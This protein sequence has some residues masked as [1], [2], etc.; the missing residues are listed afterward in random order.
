MPAKPSPVVK[1]TPAKEKSKKQNDDSDLAN[2]LSLDN[3]VK[4]DPN[5]KPQ[6]GGKPGGTGSNPKATGNGPGAGAGSGLGKGYVDSVGNHIKSRI[7]YTS[8]KG[9]PEVSYKI[10]LLPSGEVRDVILLKSSGD[11]EW[12]KA[13]ESAIRRSSPFPKPPGGASFSEFSGVEWKF[14]PK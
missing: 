3:L 11:P 8:E 14:R 5:A 1:P 10:L 9:N 4:A 6:P 13:V 12:D 2:A 7:N